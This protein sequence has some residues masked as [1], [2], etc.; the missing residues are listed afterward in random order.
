MI[1]SLDWVDLAGTLRSRQ[2]TGRQRQGHPASRSTIS[3]HNGWSMD[4]QGFAPVDLLLAADPEHVVAVARHERSAAA[5]EA[6]RAPRGL[7]KRPAAQ[8]RSRSSTSPARCATAVGERPARSPICRCPG[9]AHGGRSATRS[10][11]SAPTAAAAS[12]AGP[13]VTVGAALALKGSGRLPVGICGDGDFL[14]G[15]TA[16]WT[17]THYRIPLLIV[18]AN[19]RS[20]YNDEVH[21]ERVARMRNRPVENKWIGQRISRSRHRPRGARACA[22]RASA[23]GRSTTSHSWR[24]RSREA[25]AAVEAGG[26]RGRRRAGRARLYAGHDGGRVARGRGS[27]MA[28]DAPRP[29][30]RAAQARA[31][32]RRRR[33]RQALRDAGRRHHRGRPHLASMSRRASFWR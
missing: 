8:A 32:A 7:T 16:L 12:A 21:Q 26:G 1:L 20:F 10:T 17:A 31:R 6:P 19:N 18:V 11:S 23:S 22:R 5:H 27:V 9:T 33:H 28:A 4:H 2:G 24:A 13:G 30:R 29:T 14:M 3:I 15:V 25:I